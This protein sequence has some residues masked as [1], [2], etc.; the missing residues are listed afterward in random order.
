MIVASFRKHFPAFILALAFG[1][2]IILPA[3][4]TKFRYNVPFSNLVNIRIDDEFFYY[5]RIR[6]VIDG[7]PT[8]GNAYLWEHKSKPPSPV[9]IGE[10]LI[11]QPLKIFRMNVVAGGVLYDFL[12]PPVNFI[13]VYACF[14]IL[15]RRRWL[16]LAAA[17][18]LF[19]FLFPSDFGRSVS[20]QFNFIF[21]L[22]L[23]LLALALIHSPPPRRR[24]FLM[25]FAALNFGL[26]FY[27]Y[28]YYWTFYL[29][30]FAI[31]IFLLGF[32]RLWGE[33]KS[34]T[35]IAAGGL[36]CAVPYFLTMLRAMRLP[37]YGETLRR[38][39]LIDTRFP[40]GLAIVI[41]AVILLAVLAFSIRRKIVFWDRLTIFLASGLLGSIVVV[42][43]HIITGKNLEFS[44]HYYL[45]A[46]FW[47]SFVVA[48][49][50]S[51]LITRWTRYERVLTMC[52]GG[53]A[54]VVV[55]FYSGL[56]LLS[57]FRSLPAG[58][59]GDRYTAVMDWINR[60]VKKD[61]V[62]YASGDLSMLIPIYTS[63]NVYFA[64]PA[65]LAFVPNAEILDR[66]IINNWY[67][68]LTRDFVIANLRSIYGVYDI[69]LAAHTAQENRVRPLF[70]L[71]PLPVNTLSEDAA[72][73]VANRYA[74]LHR[75][76]FERELKKY[77]ID[78]LIWNRVSEPQARFGEL[79]FLEKLN[80]VGEFRIYR[81][82]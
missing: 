4:V 8:I 56:N 72:A 44:S 70:G 6:D 38:L 34:V 51:A 45:P 36:I 66:F 60:N 81:V 14:F 79:P 37:E 48:Y 13:L 27:I 24:Y 32:S 49:I 76:N 18:L 41:P 29:T 19:L 23:L 22:T 15:T 33:V 50:A 9:F 55:I 3:L 21:W 68:L 40:S 61:E 30:L 64:V 80:D 57:T 78:Y 43:Q 20:P 10:W 65:R 42:N 2:S 75:G 82:R 7:Y 1:F 31:F 67:R 69:D 54:A 35:A 16:A 74:E 26:L 39:G 63:A 59:S 25:F 53:L 12:L 52:L 28:A 77:R 73:K 11:A 62:V 71:P 46:A 47:M 5:A 17:A 58:N